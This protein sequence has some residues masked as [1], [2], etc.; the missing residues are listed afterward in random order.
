MQGEVVTRTSH[1]LRETEN[2]PSPGTWK[3]G[4]GTGLGRPTLTPSIKDLSPFGD[5]V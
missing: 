4:G 5:M 3:T 2:I 1:V